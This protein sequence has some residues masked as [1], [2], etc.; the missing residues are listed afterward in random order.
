[1]SEQEGQVREKD[2]RMSDTDGTKTDRY[3]SK[4]VTS[5]LQGQASQQDG[6][7]SDKNGQT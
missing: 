2:E 3:E 7:I 4:T 1:M 6:H 5:D